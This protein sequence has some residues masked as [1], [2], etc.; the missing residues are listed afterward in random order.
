[1]AKKEV[2]QNN[3]LITEGMIR[4]LQHNTLVANTRGWLYNVGINLRSG[5]GRPVTEFTLP[6]DRQK[7]TIF[8]IGPGASL[9]QYREVLPQ[10]RDH[11]TVIMQ[12]TAYPWMHRIGLEPDVIVSV[13]HMPAQVRLI[14]GATCPV[15]CPTTCDQG[16]AEEHETYFFT[17]YLG[18]G[19]TKKDGTDEGHYFAAWNHMMH[20]LH[21]YAVTEVGWV[22]AMDV[23]NMATQ[24]AFDL[25]AGENRMPKFPAKRV[26]LV[27]ADRSFWHGYQR[28]QGLN[29]GEELPK[30]KPDKRYIEFRGMMTDYVMIFYMYALYELWRLRLQ[31][32][33]RCDEGIMKEIPY[34][35]MDQILAD[36]YPRPLS[37]KRVLQR[38][39]DFI[40]H[41]FVDTMPYKWAS[42]EEVERM[43]KQVGEWRQKS[44]REWTAP[45]PRK[46]ERH[47]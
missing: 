9:S 45:A 44:E 24:I 27:G 20:H 3:L 41:E 38:T 5:L 40:L 23:T 19:T 33:Y 36:K 14:E 4:N 25:M 6:N 2:N 29:D 30:Y 13:D 26:V 18:D 34:V 37:A 28:L 39:E 11:G 42:P 47:E 35:S 46:G 31:P 7:E 22:S 8:I 16:F 32:L 12:P 10:L 17:L 15:I 43:S 1:M 21:K